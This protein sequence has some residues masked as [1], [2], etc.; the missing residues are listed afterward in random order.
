MARLEG[1]YLVTGR[2][3]E[4][5]LALR[6]LRNGTGDSEAPEALTR[7]ELDPSQFEAL[8]ARPGDPVRVT[9]EAGSTVLRAHAAAAPQPGVLFVPAGPWANALIPPRCQPGGLPAY[10]GVAASVDPA[11]GQRPASLHQL[12]G[13]QRSGGRQKPSLMTKQNPTP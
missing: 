5:G 9:T 10:K 3:T 8:G 11:P 13:D 6:G 12:A 1:L 2:S 7:C 4:Q